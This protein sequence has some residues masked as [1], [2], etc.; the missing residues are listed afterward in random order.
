M[1]S[2]LFTLFHASSLLALW[3]W[4]VIG[5]SPVVAQPD[6]PL[7]TERYRVA[8]PSAQPAT[9]SLRETLQRVAAQHQVPLTGLGS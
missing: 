9:V 8:Q 5:W 6:A 1:N 7:L 2:Y 3:A 4:L